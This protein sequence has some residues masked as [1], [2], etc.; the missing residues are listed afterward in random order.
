MKYSF[1]FPMD[2][3]RLEQFA[4]T[5]R[6]YDKMPQQKEFVIMT[7]NELKVARYLDDNDLIKDVRVIPYT[8]DRGF[9]P[10]KAFNIG[11]RNAKYNRVIITSPEVLPK[12]DVL[13]QFDGSS[14]QNIVCQVWDEDVNHEIKASLVHKGYR[15]TNP[16]MYFLAVFNKVDIEKINGWDEDFMQG[17]AYE[18]DDFGERWNRAGIPW[19][20]REDIQ[21]V[22]Q[23][24][25]R[26]ETISGGRTVNYN[27][28]QENNT[29]GIIRCKNG[30]V[31]LS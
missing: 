11:V 23:Y 30:I 25:P 1:V 8:V 28:F 10:S 9:N 12:T 26:G 4:N 24:H 22:H 2:D 5:K 29:N 15:D 27:K 20:L 19:I 6:A 13:S 18:D 17:Y 31:K 14:N 21:A 7:R 3:N 16:G